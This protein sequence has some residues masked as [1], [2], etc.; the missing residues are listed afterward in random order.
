MINTGRLSMLLDDLFNTFAMQ[1]TNFDTYL[2]LV[3]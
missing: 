1:T 2:L 3:S